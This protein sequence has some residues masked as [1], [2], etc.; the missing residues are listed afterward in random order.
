[1]IHRKNIRFLFILLTT[2]NSLV[3]EQKKKISYNFIEKSKYISIPFK[4]NIPYFRQYPLNY[5]SYNYLND[6]FLNNLS[7]ELLMGNPPQKVN[8]F[9]NQDNSCFTFIDYN[10]NYKNIETKN[11]QIKAFSPKK[12]L[13]F[14]LKKKIKTIFGEDLFSFKNDNNKNITNEIHMPF[15]I[16]T[17]SEE[18][19]EETKFINYLGLNSQYLVDNIE[20]PNFMKELKNNK[21]I[22]E[23]IYSIIYKTETQGTLFIGDNLYNI[24]ENNYNKNS[25]FSINAIQNKNGI[26]WNIGFDKIYIYD[27]YLAGNSTI[28]NKQN[29]GQIYLSNNMVVNLKID[30]KITIGTQEYKKI[31][32]DL[33]F[34]NLINSDICKIE[35][36]KYLNKNYYVYSCTALLF[37]TFESP[38]EYDDD[39]YNYGV[40]IYH[41]EHF[42]TLIFYSNKLNYSFK[43]RH[44]DLFE[45]KGDR[46]YFMIVFESE[47][48]NENFQEWIIGEH[49]IKKHIFAFNIGTK[50]IWFYNAKNINPNFKE[51]D[52]DELKEKENK[53]LNN[54]N[55]KKIFP[56]LLLFF[57]CFS[58]FSFFLGIK[59]KERRKKKANELLDEYDYISERENKSIISINTKKKHN[60]EIELN[61]KM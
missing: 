11:N 57:I 20:C 44:E 41:Y 36:V 32:D 13:T 26:K 51:I 58:I 34:N 61:S 54:D 21:L 48:I 39:Y 18:I 42:P 9:L 23:E 40:P 31:I 7:I 3:K 2:I 56:F 59:L 52:E 22:K 27:T 15:H 5:S 1:M 38:Y 47:P 4:E 45:L 25:F 53:V 29:G 37:A 43:L 33:Y 24:N 30:Q 60:Y 50:K 19:K 8:A 28:S 12:S 49:F 17:D 10:K 46:F 16:D 6:F 14:L 55:N 35:L